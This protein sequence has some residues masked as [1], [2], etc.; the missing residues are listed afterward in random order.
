MTRDRASNPIA[1]LIQELK[2]LPGIGEKGAQR[3]AFFLIQSPPELAES[4]SKAIEAARLT[5]T[6]CPV[7]RNLSSGGGKCAI[8]QDDKRDSRV[9]C[10][11]ET[12]SDLQA[13]EKSG[14]YRGRYHILHGALSPLDGFG[15]ENLRVPDLIDRIRRESVQEVILAVNPN[16]KGDAT[17]HYLAEKLVPLGIRITRIASGVPAGSELEYLDRSTIELAV[18]YRREWD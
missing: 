10:I 7:C 18:K 4:L 6:L 2:R 15:P 11:V 16:V 9:L 14:G 12:P 13:I 3:L 8:C 5:T 17:A 1:A